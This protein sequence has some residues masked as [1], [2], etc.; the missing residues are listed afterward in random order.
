MFMQQACFLDAHLAWENNTCILSIV[1]KI[2]NINFSIIFFTKKDIQT[3]TIMHK[4]FNYCA[5]LHMG[6]KMK[7]CRKMCFFI[8]LLPE[9][10]CVYDM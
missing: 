9:S 8:G 10:A 2:E 4:T 6:K 3:K 1:Y 5:L 7:K